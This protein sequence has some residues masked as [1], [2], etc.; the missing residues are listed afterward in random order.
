MLLLGSAQ[1]TP[2]YTLT[3]L[4]WPGCLVL[5]SGVAA[6]PTNNDGWMLV[7]PRKRAYE[8][9]GLACFPHC[10]PYMQ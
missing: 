4:L 7:G 9:L 5:A 8:A 10:L 6:E 2:P 1:L 3:A